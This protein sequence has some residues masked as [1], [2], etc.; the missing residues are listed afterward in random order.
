MIQEYQDAMDICRL[1]GPLDLFVTMTCNPKWPEIQREVKNCISGQ[2]TVDR[3]DTIA[4]VF[5]MKLDDVMEDMHKGNHF[6]RVKAGAYYKHGLPHCHSLIFLHKH[7][8]NSSTDEINHVISAEFPSEVDDPNMMHEP[9]GELYKSSLLKYD[10]HINVEWCNQGT[11]VKYHFSYLNKGPDHATVVIKGQINETNN[12]TT[13]TNI[14]NTTYSF[15]MTTNSNTTPTT[16][17]TN[18]TTTTTTNNNTRM[19]PFRKEG[20]N[21][22][23]F[24]GDDDVDSVIQRETAAMSKFTEWMKA[25]EMYPEL[26]SN[27]TY[28]QFPTKFTWHEKEKVWKPRKS[29]MS[30]GQIYYVSPSMGEKFYLR[31]LLNVVRGPNILY[32]VVYPKYMV[33]CKAWHFLG[34]DVKWVQAIRNAS[35][36]KL[37]DQLRE[38]FVTILLFC[39]V[40]DHNSFFKDV[41]Q[42]ISEDVVRKHHRLLHN[43]NVVFTDQEVQNYTLLELEDILNVNNK[44]LVDFLKLPR[45]D[46][47]L[48]NVGRNRLIAAERM[49]NVNEEWSRFTSLYDGLNPQQRDVYDNIMQAVNERNG[50]LFFVYG[51]GGTGKTYLWK[52]IISWIRS[53]GRIVLLVASSGISS[54][55]FPGGRTA[56]SRLDNPNAENQVFGGKVVVLVEIMRFHNW[57][58]A[59]RDGRLLCIAL[60]GEDDATWIT[61]LED[62]LIPIDDNPIEA[63]VS[64]TFPY[65]LNRIQDINYL[66]ERYILSPINDVVDKINSHILASMS[67]E[68]HELLSADTICSTTDNLE[69]MQ[70]MYPPEFLNTLRFSG[71][72]IHKLELKIGAPIILL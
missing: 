39:R 48:M 59:M 21:R 65:L 22:V 34:D 66:K 72:P 35:Q 42:Y 63:I 69:D 4:R 36:W 61:I 25:N 62:L 45:L 17:T 14:S 23:Y 46:Y 24:R 68:M 11:L 32:D 1:A 16:S 60:D 20:C 43:Q 71:V 37:G 31:T 26:G 64:S 50:G 3:P 44:S 27:L 30:L 2:P 33:I 52:T 55:L 8:K 40:F 57:L 13:M 12:S 19:L 67:G 58:I 7:D 6:G 53:L 5:K 47:T 10:F 15:R 18:N 70:I 54:L 49:Y 29:R 28:A 38:M 9:C 51:C 41:Y 56:H